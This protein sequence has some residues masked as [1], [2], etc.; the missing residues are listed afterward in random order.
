MIIRRLALFFAMLLGLATTQLPEYMQQYRQRLGGAIDEIAAIVARFEAE[1]SDL[2]LTRAEAIARLETNS[3][4][5]AEARGRDMEALVGRLAR[6][7][8]VAASLERSGAAGQWFAFLTTFDPAIAAG[9]YE[10]YQPAVPVTADGFL[11]GLIGFV[12]GG[13]LV[14]VVGLPIRYRHKFLRH[15]KVAKRAGHAG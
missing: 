15:G 2:G 11:A 1:A 9:A 3:D 10:A 4:P 12:I 8:H 6:L 14:H 7:R 13:A 5:L